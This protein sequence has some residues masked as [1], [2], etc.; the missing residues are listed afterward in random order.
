LKTSSIL[1]V[2]S[3]PTDIARGVDFKRRIGLA[4]SVMASVNRVWKDQRLTLT[5]KLQGRGGFTLGPNLG[6]APN[7][8]VTTANILR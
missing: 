8:L 6:Q 5:T 1:A 7:I 4:S 3:H 2:C